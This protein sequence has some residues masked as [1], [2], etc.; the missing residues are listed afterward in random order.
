MLLLEYLI[1]KMPGQMGLLCWIVLGK[2]I[3]NKNLHRL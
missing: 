3:I 2:K 1:F